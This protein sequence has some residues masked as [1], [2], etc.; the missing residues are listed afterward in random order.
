M[1]YSNTNKPYLEVDGDASI[2]E[3]TKQGMKHINHI[4]QL[5][6]NKNDK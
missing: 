3:K 1:Y 2:E 5:T 6:W 4:L